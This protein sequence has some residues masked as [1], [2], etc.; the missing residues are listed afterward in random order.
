MCGEVEGRRRSRREEGELISR[1]PNL[2]SVFPRF[3]HPLRLSPTNLP[4]LPLFSFTT[5]AVWLSVC[6]CRDRLLDTNK[7]SVLHATATTTPRPPYSRIGGTRHVLPSP[8]T[9]SQPTNT[10]SLTG[11]DRPFSPP[12]P[13]LPLCNISPG[14]SRT[15]LKTKPV[16]EN[17]FLLFLNSLFEPP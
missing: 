2:S 12:I 8:L 15:T 11:H 1:A 4:P 6:T 13:L 5:R 14:Y 7:P 16:L 3:L 10:D 9:A 17:Q